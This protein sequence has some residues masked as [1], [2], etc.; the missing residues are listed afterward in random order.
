LPC[1]ASKSGLERKNKKVVAFDFLLRL[2]I[3]NHSLT[4]DLNKAGHEQPNMTVRVG[5]FRGQGSASKCFQR[6]EPIIRN[7]E[8]KGKKT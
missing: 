4:V 1:S 5:S 8:R 3:S 6:L 7:V 2:D